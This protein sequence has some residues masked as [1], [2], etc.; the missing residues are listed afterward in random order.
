M[1]Q[2]ATKAM[3]ML[4]TF[5]AARCLLFICSVSCIADC[6]SIWGVNTPLSEGLGPI[7]SSVLQDALSQADQDAHSVASRVTPITLNYSI[8]HG[9]SAIRNLPNS[10]KHL[11]DIEA[12]FGE[13]TCPLAAHRACAVLLLLRG[14]ADAAHDVI[15]GVTL[16]NLEEAEYA[17]KHRGQTNW[18][19]EHPLTD[20]ADL[21][22]A[23]IHCLE[24]SA[25]GEGG[26]Q[27]YQNAKYW[28]AGGPK[29]LITPA[30]HSSRTELVRIAGEHAPYCV[31]AGVIAGE[32]GATHTIIADGG[33]TRTVCVPAGEWDG[34]V[35]VNLCE[36][37]EHGKLS[38]EQAKEVALLH[39]AQLM[40]LL[41]MELEECLRREIDSSYSS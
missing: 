35:F 3:T 26:Y 18:T 17:A 27:G 29:A 41:R 25:V 19:Q 9:T 33:K 24:K 23:A 21:I 16:H 2:G 7:R 22:H 11:V 36:Q 14:H 31:K 15:L 30:K 34:F 13:T 32:N 40:L 6:N 1:A 8:F 4:T 12:L 37:R 28:L 20:S 38:D 5:A 39:R 10:D